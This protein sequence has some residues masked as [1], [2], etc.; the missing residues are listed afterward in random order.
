MTRLRKIKG[1]FSRLW[2]AHERL[3]FPCA[4]FTF[5]KKWLLNEG[6]PLK[7]ARIMP[8]RRRRRRRRQMLCLRISPYLSFSY[9]RLFISRIDTRR[10][11]I[12]LPR[13]EDRPFF[14]PSWQTR[15]FRYGSS[16][17]EYNAHCALSK[18]QKICATVSYIKTDIAS[19]ELRLF[20]L[21]V[22]RSTL[23][24]STKYETVCPV[25]YRK[26]RDLIPHDF[27]IASHKSSCTPGWLYSL[28]NFSYSSFSRFISCTLHRLR[29]DVLQKQSYRSFFL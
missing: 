13:K 25:S 20:S 6:E 1:A 16:R 10:E 29:F 28:R 5:E 14:P 24:L 21:N 17:K 18:Y 9:R 19:S 12:V 23:I 2:Q 15:E 4:E 8:T 11:N 26:I 3:R 27:N 22:S 7:A